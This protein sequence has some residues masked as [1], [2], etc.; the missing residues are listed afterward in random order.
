MIFP[1]RYE[2]QRLITIT[3]KKELLNNSVNIISGVSVR[4]YN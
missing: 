2:K 1:I 4:R 3:F